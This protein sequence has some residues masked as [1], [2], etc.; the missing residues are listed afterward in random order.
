MAGM[1]VR[2]LGGLKRVFAATDQTSIHFACFGTFLVDVQLMCSSRRNSEDFL[3]FT[4][5]IFRHVKACQK[6]CGAVV[7]AALEGTL[8]HTFLGVYR[9]FWRGCL[10]GSSSACSHTLA[11]AV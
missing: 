4:G 8:V 9:G 6:G 7:L 10:S 1:V 11:H 5:A 2:A 3:E